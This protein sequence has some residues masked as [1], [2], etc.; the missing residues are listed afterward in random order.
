M[1][2][3]DLNLIGT[4]EELTRT[5]KYLKNEFEMK[6]LEKTK[7]RLGL[8]IEH[9]PTRVL[10]HQS[11]NAKKIL[12]HFYMDKAHL[13]SSPMVIRSLDVK[14]DPFRPYEKGEELLGPKVPY[15]SVISALI[16]LANCTR[17]HIA[18]SVNLLAKYNSAPIQRH[19]NGIKYILCYLQGTTDMSLFYS[20]EAKQQSSNCL[21]MLM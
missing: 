2:V 13:L 18:F 11:A 20:K 16:Y 5:S 7:F 14:K 15:I 21:D 8:Q 3:D 10:V 6:D 17:P 4:P 1:Y 9:F 12:K 19:W